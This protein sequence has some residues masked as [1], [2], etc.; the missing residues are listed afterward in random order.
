M[1]VPRH[2]LVH[3]PLS[4]T[5]RLC[6]WWLARRGEG[7]P[8]R[9]PAQAEAASGPAVAWHWH[10]IPA[11]LLV[12]RVVQGRAAPSGLPGAALP[13]LAAFASRGRGLWAG[14][15][16]ALMLSPEVQRPKLVICMASDDDKFI[17]PGLEESLGRLQTDEGASKQREQALHVGLEAA[18]EAGR[19][20]GRLDTERI[21]RE[22]WALRIAFIAMAISLVSLVATIVIGIVT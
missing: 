2:V 9:S 13:L 19:V 16:A 11:G 5:G 20:Q 21:S 10:P 3:A 18:R 8:A 1:H 15:S 6:G 22:M 14:Y 4:L 17:P 7:Y 12:I